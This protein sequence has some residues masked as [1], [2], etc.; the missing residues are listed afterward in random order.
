MWVKT[1]N[2]MVNTAM[3]Y[4]KD[5]KA[6]ISNLLHKDN[7]ENLRWFSFISGS[8]IIIHC[9]LY[10]EGFTASTFKK[11]KRS[12]DVVKLNLFRNIQHNIF[13]SPEN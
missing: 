10:S 4:E 6:L 2:D 11:N 9:S 12:L 8:D 3:V 7:A 13:Q 1:L 5:N